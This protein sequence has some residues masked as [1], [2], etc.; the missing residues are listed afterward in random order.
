MAFKVSRDPEIQQT[1]SVNPAPR[2]ITIA[3]LLPAVA[4]AVT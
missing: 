2:D 3:H 4:M 1:W